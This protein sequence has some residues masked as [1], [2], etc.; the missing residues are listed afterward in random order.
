MLVFII[1]ALCALG[2]LE[3]EA[4][5]QRDFYKVCAQR[6]VV[7]FRL[8]NRVISHRLGITFTCCSIHHVHLLY[9]YRSSTF[10]EMPR[11]SKS[12]RRIVSSRFNVRLVVLSDVFSLHCF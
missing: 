10:P 8:Y 1:A 12:K 6:L 2:A 7:N 5:K 4:A 3:A 11:C 9:N